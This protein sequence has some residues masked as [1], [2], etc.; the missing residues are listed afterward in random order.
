MY[1]ISLYCTPAYGKHAW[2]HLQTCTRLLA[3]GQH[4]LLNTITQLLQITIYMDVGIA[5]TS[6]DLPCRS[7]N[8]NH[9]ALNKLYGCAQFAM[10]QGMHDIG[11]IVRHLLFQRLGSKTLTSMRC[12]GACRRKGRLRRMSCSMGA[13]HVG[14]ECCRD[15]SRFSIGLCTKVYASA[16]C[17]MPY[18]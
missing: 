15:L 10:V 9:K 3:A 13:F 14:P 16:S 4:Q 18:K 17:Q 6:L 8:Y 1:C 12:F 7:G 5:H 11:N 2:Q